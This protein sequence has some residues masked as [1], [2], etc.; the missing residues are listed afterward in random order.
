[1]RLSD[2][3]IAQFV[4]M[5]KDSP[6]NKNEA[7]VYGTVTKVDDNGS[8]YVQLDGSSEQHTPVT[9]TAS[10]S[11]GDRV[12]VLIKNHTATI[13]GN[14]SSP[15]ARDKEL[16][17]LGDTVSKVGT[18]I[19]YKV[20]TEDLEAVHACIEQLKVKI[21]KLD[22]VDV[23]NAYIY[24]L[25]AKF[26]DV[27]TISVQ[28]L[29]AI[30]A[31]IEKIKATIGEFT[32]IST[33]DLEAI[34]ADIGNLKAHTAKF[35]YVFAE[36]LEAV[37]ADIKTLNADKLSATDADIK[38]ANID[39]TNIGDAAMR[40]FYSKS[41]LIDNVVVSDG[42]ITGNLVGVTIKGDLIEGNT[43]KADKLVVKGTDGLYYKL[44]FEGGEFAAGEVV[45]D[46]SLHGSIIT[47]K[48]ITATKISVDDLV[49]F[50]ATIGGFNIDSGSIYSGVKESINNTT[51]GI[52]LGYDG[53]VSL[54]DANNFLKFYIN[55]A[56]EYKLAISADS[57]LFGGGKQS[58]SDVVDD[59][60]QGLQL[61]GR[62]LI[63]NST[64]LVF[65]NYSFVEVAA[66][67]VLGSATIGTMVLGEG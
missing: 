10:V 7:T 9:S 42:T 48:S 14:V 53:Q 8:A 50:D 51:R 19:S 4:K 36:I 15:S 17:D 31:N 47:A 58:I 24:N 52:Y 40:Y 18:V 54:G 3:L 1:M 59:G 21:A 45:P 16:K 55:E 43:V 49:A 2:D 39:F 62:N 67:A 44:N 20:S 60:L 32:D 46:D 5:T 27:E 38:Y 6:D 30:N 64:S 33:E 11:E 66:T 63:R 13:T 34:N 57:I 37:R 65:T 22:N 61:G 35:T 26:A 41:G 25:E 12:T 29:K 28:D 23:L 56:G